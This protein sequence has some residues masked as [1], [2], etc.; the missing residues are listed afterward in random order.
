MSHLN[1]IRG[2]ANYQFGE[3]IGE[4]MFSKEIE[5]AFSKRT[6]RIRHL[7][8]DGKLL[9]TLRPTDGFFSLTIAGAQKLC[10]I[11]KAPRFR[12]VITETVEEFAKKGRNI[13]A[14][15]VIKADLELRSGEETIITDDNDRV[16]AVGRA[17]LTGSEM[18]AFKRGVAIKTRR[19]VDE[20]KQ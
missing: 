7:Y 15:H 12:V 2:V 17:L 8:L 11:V 5:I 20:S 9:A 10:T 16:L 1:R 13:F 3:N 19:G 6:G 18:L 4:Q 14:R